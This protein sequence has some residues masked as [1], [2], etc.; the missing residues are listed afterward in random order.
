MDAHE[1][2]KRKEVDRT[3]EA[4]NGFRLLSS[5]ARC[6]NG[7]QP[8]GGNDACVATS[9]RKSCYTGSGT[10]TRTRLRLAPRVSPILSGVSLHSADLKQ[11][12]LDGSSADFVPWDTRCPG[13]GHIAQDHAVLAC[14]QERHDDTTHGVEGGSD[15]LWQH[16]DA[17]PPFVGLENLGNT[18]YINA[19]VQALLACQG[20]VVAL[21]R[22][23][24][25]T[26]EGEA[27]KPALENLPTHSTQASAEHVP[28]A[29]CDSDSQDPPR[30]RNMVSEALTDLLEAMLVCNGHQQ[31]LGRRKTEHMPDEEEKIDASKQRERALLELHGHPRS[32]VPREFVYRVCRAQGVSGRTQVGT[33]F[34]LG[35]QCVSEFLG[36]LF[37]VW[38]RGE[39]RCETVSTK[40]AGHDDNG[41]AC[42][43]G[44]AAC[45]HGS[46]TQQF[47]GCFCTRTRCMECEQVT[48]SPDPFTEL[49]LPPPLPQPPQ[50]GKGEG[51]RGTVTQVR[52]GGEQTPPGTYAGEENLDLPHI[53][54]GGLI[55]QACT[56]EALVGQEKP[57]CNVCHSRTEAERDTILACLPPLLILHL[58]PWPSLVT[59]LGERIP[60]TS[61][62]VP[63]SYS[64]GCPR[65]GDGELKAG[66]GLGRVMGRGTRP[67]IERE[68]RFQQTRNRMR[69]SNVTG[70]LSHSGGCVR[71]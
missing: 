19:V 22:T 3:L 65:V 10:R 68:L 55:N 70:Q 47:R 40:T 59:G 64:V 23:R 60:G 25:P 6:E 63:P 27:T 21:G 14:D 16:V 44:I 53:S 15:G 67:A 18:C 51:G 9:H 33:P 69:S 39:G 7:D 26:K 61:S 36:W 43:C 29:V 54:L 2:R 34:G 28:L 62:S 49:T 57:K 11:P 71:G 46:L 12:A 37:G 1:T 13:L 24:D 17:A 52:W 66:Q 48:L 5:R 42:A 45:G 8:V 38:G 41:G 58:K 35:Q 4:P 20:T 56:V 30:M 31:R 32:L 50:N